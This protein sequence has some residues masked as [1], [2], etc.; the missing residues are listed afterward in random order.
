MSAVLIIVSV[1]LLL[2][3]VLGYGMLRFSCG[4]CKKED[5]FDPAVLEKNTPYKKEQTLENR[6]WFLSQTRREIVS[7]TSFDGLRLVGHWV[8]WT[9][10]DEACRNAVPEGCFYEGAGRA[11]AAE[12]GSAARASSATGAEADAAKGTVICFHGWKGSW[13]SNY[14]C[15]LKFFNGLG[16][17]VLAVEERAQN[18]SE[19]RYMTFGVRERKDLAQWVRFVAEK[20][21]SADAPQGLPIFLHGISMGSATV[22]MASSSELSGCVKGIIADCGY[23]SPYAIMQN[24]MESANRRLAEKKSLL[25]IPVGFSLWLLNIF[26]Q[27]FAGFGLLEWSAPQALAE[28]RYPLLFVHGTGDTFVPHSMSEENYAA[29]TAEK[30]LL[31]IPDAPH[32]Q[33]WF[34]DHDRVAAA[35]AAFLK[36]YNR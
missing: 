24:I 21:A 20:T 28:S 1:L 18:N 2:L 16:Y 36:K 5:F 3:L 15:Y 13:K 29:C 30:E 23:T 11:G 14:A 34:R 4:K 35:E 12:I 9:G 27:A 8:P 22:Q 10:P 25:R 26:A 17:N 33:C 32:T 6:D 31:L 7:V 19:G